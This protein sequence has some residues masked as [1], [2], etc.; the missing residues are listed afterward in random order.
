MVI[1]LP[2][3]IEEAGNSLPLISAPSINLIG[4]ASSSEVS[5]A[6]PY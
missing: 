1:L 4:V 3:L 5:I 2:Q 6:F